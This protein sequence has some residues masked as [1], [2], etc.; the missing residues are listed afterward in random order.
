MT[1]YS[2]GR[3]F[4]Y[5][6]KKKFE[7]AGFFCVRSAG[8]HGVFDLLCVR[9]GIPWGV[10][11]KVGKITE[12]EKRRIVETGRKYGIVPCLATK[13]DGKVVVVNLLNGREIL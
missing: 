7:E 11:C 3:R 9:N 4:E 10:Q 1:R 2:K 8:S 12:E 5:E 13:R 6:V